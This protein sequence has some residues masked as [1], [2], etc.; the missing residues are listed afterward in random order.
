MSHVPYSIT[1]TVIV[2]RM[3]SPRRL[4]EPNSLT[5]LCL[6]PN[7]MFCIY[8]RAP[9]GLGLY[10]RVETFFVKGVIKKSEHCEMKDK[11]KID[12]HVYTEEDY[13]RKIYYIFNYFRAIILERLGRF[14]WKSSLMEML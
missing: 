1:S 14:C 13:T 3:T 8:K 12:N 2:P 11:I 9:T 4:V 7:C 6:D 5:I 10:A